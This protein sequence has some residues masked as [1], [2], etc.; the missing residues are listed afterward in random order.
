MDARNAGLSWANVGSALGVTA[1]AA[2]KRWAKAIRD[3]EENVVMIPSQ[4]D[5]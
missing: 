2:Q 4:S 1:Q 3:Y 5:E